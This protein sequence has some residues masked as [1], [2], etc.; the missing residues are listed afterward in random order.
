MKELE[1]KAVIVYKTEPPYTEEARKKGVTGVV[2]LRVVLSSTGQVI[3]PEVLKSLPN[4]LTESAL[5]VARHIRFFPA[6]KDGRPVSQYATL[7]Y[8][9]NIY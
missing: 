2:R 4:G 1:Q 7:E 6:Q 5:R 9:F 3:N 8:N